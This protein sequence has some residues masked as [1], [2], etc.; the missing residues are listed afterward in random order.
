MRNT[1][2]ACTSMELIK[3]CFQDLHNDSAGRFNSENVTKV[4]PYDP[5]EPMELILSEAAA[6][7]GYF[8]LQSL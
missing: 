5:E 4:G 7:A 1:D 8:M 6:I 2:E 3:L